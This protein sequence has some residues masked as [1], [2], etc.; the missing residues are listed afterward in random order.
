MRIESSV[1]V[2]P[3]RAFLVGV[4]LRKDGGMVI[5]KSLLAAGLYAA[6]NIV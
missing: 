4:Y 2:K 5:D 6:G 1:G 3:L